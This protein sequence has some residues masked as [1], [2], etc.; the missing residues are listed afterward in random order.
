MLCYVIILI[1]GIYLTKIQVIRS[2]SICRMPICISDNHR[3]QQPIISWRF[4]LAM[5]CCAWTTFKRQNAKPGCSNIFGNS[6]YLI[7]DILISFYTFV[8]SISDMYFIYCKSVHWMP[9]VSGTWNWVY[10]SG[11]NRPND[12]NK[13]LVPF[14]VTLHFSSALICHI[15]L[16]ENENVIWWIQNVHM[17][18]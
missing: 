6:V 13:C 2:L 15:S 12:L 4:R 17:C 5:C 11:I 10:C 7:N 8:F 16:S 9:S 1:C 18:F 14:T 3:F